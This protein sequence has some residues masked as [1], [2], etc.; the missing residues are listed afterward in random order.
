MM[1]YPQNHA[2]YRAAVRKI[3]TQVMSEGREDLIVAVDDF[4]WSD[5]M[6]L[7]DQISAYIEKRNLR[8]I[9]TAFRTASLPAERFSV[10][11]TEVR[12]ASIHTSDRFFKSFNRLELKRG[13]AIVG[14]NEEDL[15]TCYNDL[16]PSPS[17]CLTPAAL[18]AIEH[19]R[20]TR[21][22]WREG[23]HTDR[24]EAVARACGYRS[25][26][27]AQGRRDFYSQLL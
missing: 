9:T 25:W 14:D 3:L 10:A 19:L 5:D 11:P 27:A 8:F 18:R 1:P 12:M 2:L 6:D 23:S 21:P 7:L 15:F 16:N 24:L 26:H 17:S 4:D 20:R 13:E 22:K